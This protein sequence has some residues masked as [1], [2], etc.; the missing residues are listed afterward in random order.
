[1]TGADGSGMPCNYHAPVERSIALDADPMSARAARR[2]VVDALTDWR[3]PQVVETAELLISELVTNALLHARSDAELVVRRSGGTVRFEVS[4]HSSA[5]P[6]TGHHHQESQTGRGLE[7]V[8]LLAD[9][10]GVDVHH[11]GLG[12]TGKGVWFELSVA[13][14]PAP[15]DVPT[16]EPGRSFA[17]GTISVCLQGVPTALFR[18]SQDHRQD[19]TREFVLMTIEGASSDDVPARLVALSE[20][21]TLRFGSESAATL[22][23]VHE[24]E[25][26]GECT[27]DLVLELPPDAAAPVVAMVDLLEE[28]DR[29]CEQ[30]AMLTMAASAEVRAF[31]RWCADEVVAQLQG[32]PGTPWRRW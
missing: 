18:A 25:E 11:R 14:S 12:I 7:L 9:A 13:D 2:F 16:Q 19:L 5:V 17:V 26:R 29:F 30:G 21:V 32:R 31:R 22:A 28:A 20:E 24:A 27:V 15:P 1:M 8:E 4:D 3:M 23:Q 10:W 6:T